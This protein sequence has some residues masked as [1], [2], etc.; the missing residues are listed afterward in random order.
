M[1]YVDR[2]AELVTGSNSHTNQ[3]AIISKSLLALYLSLPYEVP[4]D[5]LRHVFGGYA[6]VPDVV[7]EDED[8]GP[9]FV[10]ASAG[11]AEH[12][13]RRETKAGDL[14]AKP[15]EKLAA[16]LLPTPP[17]PRRGADKDLSKLS[18]TSILS[19]AQ[20]LSKS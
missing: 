5:D 2:F 10:T 14:L 20:P 4:S 8:D 7:R 3:L 16:A 18:H 17:L 13:R 6:G 1:S 15:L 12:R 19:R 11:V 9:L